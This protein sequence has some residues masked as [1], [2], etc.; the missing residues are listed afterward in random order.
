MNRTLLKQWLPLAVY[1]LL[2]HYSTELKFLLYSNKEILLKN[3][4]LK[5]LGKGKRAFLLATG[6][7]IK[8]ENLK[9]LSGEDCF[10]IS[11]FFLH[12]D[13]QSINSIFHGF[14]HLHEPVTLKN[15]V[16][17]FKRADRKLPARTKM[18]L[19]YETYD[20]VKKFGLFP[21][22][23]IYYLYHAPFVMI[24]S[25][26]LM[27]P[28]PSPIT[29]PLLLLPLMIYMEYEQI[30]LLGCDHTTIRDY[31]KIVTNFYD[32]DQDIHQNVTDKSYWRDIETELSN[33]LKVFEEYRF[34]K[35]IL[36]GTSTKIINL[37]VDSW[38]EMFPF[39]RLEHISGPK[40][41]KKE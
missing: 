40:A 5:G 34:Y 28:I 9:L 36:R 27:K 7:S 2:R 13:V 11:N 32:H 6:P 25:V 31:K 21:E 26:D 30:Y 10:S 8:Q 35:N 18:V 22:R 17:L 37:S 20:I 15:Y 16:E 19:N 33:N 39:D 1:S 41:S 12:A 38:L 23:E 14:G 24:R 3:K 4:E 29:Q